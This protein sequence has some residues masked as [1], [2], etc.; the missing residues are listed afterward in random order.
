MLQTV[1]RG[2][3]EADAIEAQWLSVVGEYTRSG[4]WQADGYVSAAAA[5]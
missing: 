2:R 1:A 4:V 5:I 3:R